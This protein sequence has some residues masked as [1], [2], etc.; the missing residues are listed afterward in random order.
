[1]PGGFVGVDVFF[2][3]SGFLITG[4]LRDELVRDGRVR[5][6][7]FW[8]RRARRLLP[9]A[10]LVLAATA[11]AAVLVLS[12]LRARAVLGD[13]LA[14]ALYAGNHRFALASTDYLA[15]TDAVSPV[16]HFWSLGVEEQFYVLWPLVLLLAVRARPGRRPRTGALLPVVLLVVAASFA[17]CVH[18]TALAQPWAFFSLPTRAWEL[19]TGGAVA[20][21][22]PQ[23]HRTAAQLLGW[24]GALLLGV[25]VV[26]LDETTAFPGTAA[27]LPVLGTAA[28]VAAGAGPSAAGPGRLL[29]LPLLRL[30]GRLSYS[31]YLWHWPV[32][33]LAEAVAGPQGLP[34]RLALVALSAGL[35]AATLALLEHPVRHSV[36]LARRPGL[37]LTGAL[38]AA[39]AVAAGLVLAPAA[40]PTAEG[41][42]A[43][44]PIAPAVPPPVGSSA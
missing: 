33:V 26:A 19:A 40:L 41:A 25:A 2:V 37:V 36:A 43:A 14:A 10:L 44:A 4:L 27:L 32:L 31:W 35:A 39:A 13:A 20:V 42:V 24:T 7:R 12:P 28:L 6:L 23:L 22:A 18:L 16:L 29:A 8:A 30:A 21:L 15:D 38:A 5:L 9:A 3:L 1:V 11:G 17:A 34:V